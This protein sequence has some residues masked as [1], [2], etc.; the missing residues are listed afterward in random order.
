[1]YRLES[2]RLVLIV[3]EIDISASRKIHA[4]FVGIIAHAQSI[5]PPVGFGKDLGQNWLGTGI[6]AKIRLGTGIWAKIRLGTGIWVKTLDWE[7]GYFG[8][9]NVKA[10]NMT[11]SQSK[12]VLA[13]NV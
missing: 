9:N 7:L 10:A 8:P 5:F 4:H 6:W 1:M 11:A 13:N 12:A 2:T 3:R